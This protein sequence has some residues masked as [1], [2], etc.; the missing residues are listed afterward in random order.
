MSWDMPRGARRLLPSVLLS[1]LSC[2]LGAGSAQADSAPST[3]SGEA[4]IN[5]CATPD[6]GFGDYERWDRGIAFGQALIDGDRDRGDTFDLIVHFHG[7]EAARKA[8]V[9][10]GRGIVLA[11]ID[12]GVGSTAYA[13]RFQDPR[14]FP[15]LIASI[16]EQVAARRGLPRARLRYL[17]LS[18]WSAGYGAVRAILSDPG[19]YKIDAVI[20]LD[21]L[22]SGYADPSHQIV[23]E[24]PLQPLR[25]F[26]E[27]AAEGRGFWFQTYSSI[28][29]P[30]YASTREVASWLVDSLGGKLRKGRRHD[31]LGLEL[32]EH[33]DD[34]NLHVR[35]YAGEDKRAHCAHVGML[36]V[37][38]K[39]HL[40]RRWGLPAR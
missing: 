38:V 18:S 10:V 16:A 25:A 32:I 30:G 36:G 33:F 20:L 28:R 7:H 15:T 39:A 2:I 31:P 27:R 19:D 35:G 40:W 22:Y 23:K 12:E 17:A 14:A 26:A 9:P 6:P 1:L 8:F 34:D 13:A 11:G 5:P 3:R 4:R 37:V 24:R 29:T 21:S